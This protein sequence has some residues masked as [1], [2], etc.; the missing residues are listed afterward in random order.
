MNTSNI[1][2]DGGNAQNVNMTE[3]YDSAFQH[4]PKDQGNLRS[5]KVWS[6]LFHCSLLSLNM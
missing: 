6:A 2:R 3:A 4:S 5:V 1:K